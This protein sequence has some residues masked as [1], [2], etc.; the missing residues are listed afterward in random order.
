[1]SGGNNP[2]AAPTST[3]ASVVRVQTSDFAARDRFEAWREI[4]G[5]AVMKLE[6][7]RI[8]DRHCL[9][10]VT[11]RAL[12]DLYMS[13]G[14]TTGMQFRRPPALIDSD[15][16]IMHV[17]LGGGFHGHR[18]DLALRKGE[19]VLLSSEEPGLVSV[20]DEAFLIFR[21]PLRVMSPIV[22]DLDSV[23]AKPISKEN[24]ACGSSSAMRVAF[25]ICLP[26]PG[27]TSATS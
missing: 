10:D 20:L 27:P 15:D 12:P 8:K 26:Q 22:G 13:S 7:E 3:D 17:S 16:L 21:V 4:V 23:M 5:R 11:L 6:I 9:G 1:M 18:H 14:V 2:K 19:A 25:A 24:E